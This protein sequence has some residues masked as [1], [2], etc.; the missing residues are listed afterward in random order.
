ME[1]K[2]SNMGNED[3]TRGYAMSG[4][5]APQV[6]SAYSPM[7]LPPGPAQAVVWNSPTLVLVQRNP[8][9]EHP[10]A[11]E[12]PLLLAPHQ[13]GL[14]ILDSLDE[15]RSMWIV[16]MTPEGLLATESVNCVCLWRLFPDEERTYLTALLC[17]SGTIFIADSEGAYEVDEMTRKWFVQGKFKTARR[18]Q[19]AYAINAVV[20]AGRNESDR[21]RIRS[22]DGIEY[23]ITR[24]TI[25]VA[26]E[27]L[28][29]GMRVECLVSRLQRV[30][31]ASVSPH[32]FY[33][34][35]S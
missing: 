33:A 6:G 22:E 14:D 32:S 10:D 3:A 18:L 4:V 12:H 8:S 13:G 2:R 16:R 19:D 34:A 27:T 9:V 30:L 21:V 26:L 35:E 29:V 7:E 17:E 1:W 31:S 5:D 15:V 25:G 23:L 11:L 28:E 20:V 24:H